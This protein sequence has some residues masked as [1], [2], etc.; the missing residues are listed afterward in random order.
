MSPCP[1]IAQKDE[2]DQDD[3][4]GAFDQ[5]GGDGADDAIDQRA[6]VV[7]RLDAPRR[8]GWPTDSAAWL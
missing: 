5:V 1:D 6:A 7:E 2:Q 8:A 4:G 3:Q